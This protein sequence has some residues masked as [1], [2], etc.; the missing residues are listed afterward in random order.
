MNQ[1]PRKY[2]KN[3]Q[4]KLIKTRI[5]IKKLIKKLQELQNQMKN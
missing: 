3:R 1:K 2:K 5:K 4:M